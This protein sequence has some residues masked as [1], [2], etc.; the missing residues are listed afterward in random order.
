[1]AENTYPNPKMSQSKKKS[2][3][4]SKTFDSSCR[5]HGDCPW[6]ESGRQHF[7]RKRRKA[8]DLD[9]KEYNHD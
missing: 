1:M 7:D 8:A 2:Y 9:M 4:G 5:N 6:C 3:T